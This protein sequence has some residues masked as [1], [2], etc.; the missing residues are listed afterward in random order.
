MD[1]KTLRNAVEKHTDLILKPFDLLYETLGFE[2]INTLSY[3]FGGQQIYIP[4]PQFIFWDCIR[5][6]IIEEYNGRNMRELC[7]RYGVSWKTIKSI[8]T[9]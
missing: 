5:L 8:V 6:Q 9:Q 1:K 7:Q 3:Y 2:A 4:R